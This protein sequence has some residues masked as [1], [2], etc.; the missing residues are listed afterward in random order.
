MT[1]KKTLSR[2]G[3]SAQDEATMARFTGER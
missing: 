3:I 1:I 2:E